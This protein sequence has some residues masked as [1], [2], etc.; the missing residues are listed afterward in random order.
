[1]PKNERPGYES[2]SPVSVEQLDGAIQEPRS[3]KP[4]K[5]LLDCERKYIDKWRKKRG[6]PTSSGQALK[7][8]AIS[9]GGIRSATFAL[10]VLQAIAHENKRL[11]I[12][13]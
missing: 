13:R 1:M 11:R 8:L 5:A 6:D 3:T 7:G 4:W 9:G 10:G 2:I 12:S